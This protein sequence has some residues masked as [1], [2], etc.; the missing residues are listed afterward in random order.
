MSDDN[1]SRDSI[2][3][4]WGRFR[5]GAV[6]RFAVFTLAVIIV[7]IVVARSGGWLW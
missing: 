5:A 7:V 1:F 6:G 2:F 4:S 3:I